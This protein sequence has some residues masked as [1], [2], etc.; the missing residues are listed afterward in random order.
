M[1][2]A[3]LRKNTD[4]TGH[5]KP[6]KRGIAEDAKDFSQKTKKGSVNYLKIFDGLS[7][8]RKGFCRISKHQKIKW[9]ACEWQ[10]LV[11]W[12]KELPSPKCWSITWATSRIEVYHPRVTQI[13]WMFM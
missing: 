6:N 10:I 7:H 1:A 2:I 8:R 13:G 3:A 4:A 11:Q 5:L 9:D 12:K